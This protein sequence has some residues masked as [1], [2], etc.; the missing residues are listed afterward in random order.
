MGAVF[1]VELFCDFAPASHVGHEVGASWAEAG[2]VVDTVFAVGA[3]QS[4][5]S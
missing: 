1:G 2:C 4:Q 5:I 3:H